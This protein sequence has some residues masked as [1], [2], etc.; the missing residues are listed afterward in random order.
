MPLSALT[1]T[2]Q[3]AARRPDCFAKLVD[4][5][6]TMGAANP[7]L[8]RLKKKKK[9]RLLLSSNTQ[10]ARQFSFNLAY[11]RLVFNGL[12]FI[13]GTFSVNCEGPHD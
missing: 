4:A 11:E 3:R 10:L 8:A 13:W 2:T 1:S 12:L 5:S 6:T 9:K 7:A